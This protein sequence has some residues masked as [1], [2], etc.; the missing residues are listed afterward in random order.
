MAVNSK[1]H[2]K[3]YPQTG[4][5]HIFIFA[6]RKFLDQMDEGDFEDL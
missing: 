2:T 5:F 3:L 4:M 1:C 6:I